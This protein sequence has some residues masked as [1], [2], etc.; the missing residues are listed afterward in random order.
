MTVRVTLNCAIKPE[1]YPE[2]ETFLAANLPGVREFQGNLQVKVLI[3][4]EHTEILLDEE[5]HSVESHQAYLEFIKNNGV[6]AQLQAFLKAPPDIGYFQA[7][8]I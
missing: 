3:N 7:L 4:A 6:L 5:W 1:K 8:A 2:L